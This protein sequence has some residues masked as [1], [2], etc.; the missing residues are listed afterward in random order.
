[1]SLNHIKYSIIN[2]NNIFISFWVEMHEV[3]NSLIQKY[4]CNIK[5]WLISVRREARMHFNLLIIQRIV[6]IDSVSGTNL[7]IKRKKKSNYD[8]PIIRE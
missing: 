1:M 3:I 2:K 4:V 7:S 5:V 6:C 8:S